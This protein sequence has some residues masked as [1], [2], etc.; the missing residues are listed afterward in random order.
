M[1]FEILS[2]S[3][4]R[5][6]I[7]ELLLCVSI[8]NKICCCIVGPAGSIALNIRQQL[9]EHSPALVDPAVPFD[10]Y[11]YLSPLFDC[12]KIYIFFLIGRI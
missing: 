12:C 5:K 9:Q 10:F 1:L 4:N 8:E 7:K 2:H 3:S 6:D 11:L